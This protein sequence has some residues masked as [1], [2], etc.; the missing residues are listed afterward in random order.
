VKHGYTGTEEEWVAAVESARTSAESSA[1]AAAASQ[2][3]A[4][5]SAT[6]AAASAKNAADVSA[7]IEKYVADANSASAAAKTSETNAKSSET[8]A[9]G[10]ASDAAASKTAAAGSASTAAESQSAAKTSETSA[11]ASASAAKAS[12]TNAKSSETAAESSATTAAG[13]AEAAA[14]SASAAA[15]SETAAKGSETA[16]SGSA[17][18][19]KTSELAAA[20]DKTAAE[21]AQAVADGRA[22]DA[23]AWA[24]GQR[25]GTDV[26][27]TDPTYHNNSKYY[28]EQ[29][30]A[31]V[32]GDYATKTEAQGYV[33][34]HN[35]ASE[36]HSALFKA[37]SDALA[38]HIA[39]T[40]N[41]HGV[42]KAQVGLGSVD[43]TAD[44]AKPVSTAQA[45]AIAAAKS[46]AVTAS[47]SYTDSKVAAIDMS[48]KA[49]K[50]VPAAA[51]NLAAL[52]SSGNL[53][54]SGKAQDYYAP[55][56]TTYT[57][58]EADTLLNNKADKTAPTEYDLPLASGIENL[59][60]KY[61]KTQENIVL[62]YGQLHKTTGIEINEQIA[63]L[64]SG[65]RPAGNI[66]LP[67]TGNSANGDGA[68]FADV[69]TDGS[70]TIGGNNGSKWLFV[71]LMMAFVSG[72]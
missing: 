34:T 29:A 20:A 18:A 28:K 12:E 53:S 37:Q 13:K 46:E 1:S 59:R 7:G 6:A 63:V 49:D 48:T 15:A 21:S 70:I 60:L 36:A 25:G 66:T 4:A 35:Q 72:S 23:E 54:D 61:C 5:E 26:G 67:V 33:D 42:T 52:D 71:R 58:T 31:I 69:H 11:A 68:T 39:R 8:S 9:A 50:K 41:P 32:G 22:G 51:G 27:A 62:C 24:V 38:A 65:F 2:S 47:E 10:S 30:A 56:S 14:S 44:S 16:A 17:S 40:D 43:N 55:Q 64:P 19:A 57:K 3:A 45:A